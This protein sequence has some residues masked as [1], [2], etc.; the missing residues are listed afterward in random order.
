MTESLEQERIKASQN[1][2]GELPAWIK[3]LE[4]GDL[5]ASVKVKIAKRESAF[6]HEEPSSARTGEGF[7]EQVRESTSQSQDQVEP[8]NVV[9]QYYDEVEEEEEKFEFVPG[10]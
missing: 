4:L 9:E 3:D 1:S 6:E 10:S 8:E 2:Q 5:S 7:F